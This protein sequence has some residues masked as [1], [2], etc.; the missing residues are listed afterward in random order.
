MRLS[1]EQKIKIISIVK[2]PVHSCGEYDEFRI[3]SLFKRIEEILSRF[4]SDELKYQDNDIIKRINNYIKANVSVRHQYFSFMGEDSF[5]NNE[6]YYRTAH[7]ALFE[8]EAMCAG[9][10]EAVRCLLAAYNIDSYTLIS[11]LPG[12]NKQLLH[13]VCVVKDGENYRIID[14]ER[15]SSCERKGYDFQRYINGMTFIIPG[16]DF[17]DEKIGDTGV[18]IKAN[19][20]LE[21][22]SGTNNISSLIMKMEE[23]KNG[24]IYNGGRK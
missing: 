6:I 10:T 18:G 19:D 17:A 2:E 20:Y 23:M 14:P 12:S 1:D 21:R 16:D 7:A 15:E 4:E 13:Y 11:R 3:L 5:D 24:T 9:Y 8:H 22:S